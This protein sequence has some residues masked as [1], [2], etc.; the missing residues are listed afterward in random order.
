MTQILEGQV[1]CVGFTLVTVSEISQL[2][3]SLETSS[4]DFGFSYVFE[5]GIVRNRKEYYKTYPII[6]FP[7]RKLGCR[8]SL[9][10]KAIDHYD[11]GLRHIVP[12]GGGGGG[13][14]AQVCQ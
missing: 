4:T 3:H 8:D 11:Q 2:G 14:R 7:F 1:L 12:R 9:Y 5:P 10:R 13:E 6:P